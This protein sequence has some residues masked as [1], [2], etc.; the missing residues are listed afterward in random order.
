MTGNSPQER[1]D[2]VPSGGWEGNDEGA[3]LPEIG[4]EGGEPAP[5]AT[6]RG[7]VYDLASLGSLA[8]GV[9]VLFSCLTC[10]TGYYCLPFVPIA[11][12]LFGL[13][14]ARQAVDAAR[15]RLLSWL[16]LAAGGIILLIVAAFLA[17]YIALIVVMIA[18]G[19]FD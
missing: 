8:S 15:T 12:G 4:Q 3:P 19:Q 16:G 17:G 2:G 13:L 7:N 6:C 11:L 9:L 18:T 5:L 14:T 1:T 10:N